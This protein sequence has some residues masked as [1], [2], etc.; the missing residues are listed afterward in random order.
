MKESG[1]TQ[2]EPQFAALFSG[3]QA[4]GTVKIL[5]DPINPYWAYWLESIGTYGTSSNLVFIGLF[6]WRSEKG[7]FFSG[8]F[9]SGN[10]I[11]GNYKF[12]TVGSPNST[13]GI[14]TA[15]RIQ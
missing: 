8:N 11:S 13:Y 5:K 15:A 12:S 1:E 6:D 14:W 10:I 7:Y 9:A 3:T 4:S 2:A